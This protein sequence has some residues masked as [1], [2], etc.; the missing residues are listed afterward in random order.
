ILNI[1]IHDQPF[2]SALSYTRPAF[3]PSSSTSTQGPPLTRAFLM[4]HFSFWSWPL[5]SIGSIPRAAAA[6]DAIESQ[7]PFS[8]KHPR[9]AWR[10]TVGWSGAHYP[11]QREALLKAAGGR[12][13]ADVL[14]LT[15][16]GLEKTGNQTAAQR[17]G[18]GGNNNNA[19][20]IEDFCRY[21]HVLYTEGITYSG[22]LHFLHM[23]GS[24]LLAPPVAWL[25]HT[26]HLVRPVWSG[27]L[28][29]IN[30]SQGRGGWEPDSGVMEAWRGYPPEEA[31]AVFVAPDWSD[32]ERTVRWLEDNPRVAEGIAA[33]QREVFVGRGYLSPAAEVCYWRALVRGWSQ[34]VR[35]D[36]AE[37]EGREAVSWETF[38]LGHYDTVK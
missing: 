34:A 2:G 24:V 27:D 14:A 8:Q 31:N 15:G 4:P 12:V 11:G 38:S 33:R 6:I 25:Q 20:M 1:N 29:G 37:W 13:W 22:R 21:K 18:G 19:L 28:Y 26:T 3:R 10:G 23:C 5:P 9:L 30:T 36:V 7:T 17:N 32:L 16:Y 35:Y